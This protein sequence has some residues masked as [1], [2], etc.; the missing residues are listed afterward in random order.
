MLLI[1]VDLVSAGRADCDAEKMELDT[2]EGQDDPD[3]GLEPSCREGGT[4][5][6]VVPRF[7]STSRPIQWEM[8]SMVRLHRHRPTTD[9]S[10]ESC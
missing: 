7:C 9:G 5:G 4:D 10:P 3:T 6:A 1:P 2:D 8:A